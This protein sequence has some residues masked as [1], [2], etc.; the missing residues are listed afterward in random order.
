MKTAEWQLF[1]LVRSFGG[2]GID[3]IDSLY[4]VLKIKEYKKEI[5]KEEIDLYNYML[6]GFKWHNVY[7]G[8]SK[9]FFETF[10]IIDYV[11]AEDQIYFYLNV[12]SKAI[13]MSSKNSEYVIINNDLTKLMLDAVDDDSKSIFIPEAYM[14]G[15][16]LYDLVNNK[17]NKTFYTTVPSDE[18]GE[19]VKL[20]Y[21]NLENVKFINRNIY[22]EDFYIGK[23]DTII[24]M[25]AMGVR[26]LEG[27]GTFI[28][29]DS[30]LIAAQNLLY[31]L[32]PN[33]RLNIIL[34]AKVTF[35]GGDSEIFREYI[36]DNYKINFIYSLPNKIFHPYMSINTYMFGFSIGKTEDILIH[37]YSFE[38]DGLKLY[39]DNQKLLFEDEFEI[40]NDWSVD[41]VFIQEDADFINYQNSNIKKEKI[42]SI[43]S[44]FRG[45]SVTSKDENGNVSVINISNIH[46]YG[47]DYQELDMIT[48]EERKVSR[49]I[50]QD[51][52][53]LVTSRGTNIKV[54]VFKEQGKICIPSSNINVIRV[55]P[56]IINGVYLKL[57]LESTVGLK[58]LQSI[59]RGATIVNI[60]YQDIEMLEVPVPALEIQNDLVYKYESAL[61][62][63]LE[64]TQE[65]EKEWNKVK[66]KVQNNLY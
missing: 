64:V 25:P 35:G 55:E 61:Q 7:K 13:E 4:R 58:L 2:N 3:V 10:N 34:P 46:E 31:H 60:N 11:E 12:I 26:G 57:F 24:C 53:V 18:L 50:L 62:D 40:L 8:D 6:T 49:Y 39:D 29:K 30:A 14:F 47:I 32:T 36:A 37:K 1:N 59:Q 45:K 43:G 9:S 41:S 42:Q 54:A 22:K 56:K 21:K 17:S 27:E 16:Y 66:N 28:S 52:D 63:Y 51:G 23:F 38:N 15:T 19:L 5:P 44:A 20:I 33:G 65:A 48:E